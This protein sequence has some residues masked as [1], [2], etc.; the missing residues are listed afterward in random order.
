MNATELDLVKAVLP[1]IGTALG[2]PLGAGAATFVASK[3]G[4]SDSSVATVK[5]TIQNMLGNPEQIAKLKEIEN[6]YQ[7][8]M[9]EAGYTHLEHLEQI[10][11]SV[12]TTQVTA[13]NASMQAESRSNHWPTYTWRPFIGFCFGFMALSVYFVLPLMKLPVP[14][15]PSEVWLGYGA[16]LGTA[17]FFRGK[18]QADPNVMLDNRG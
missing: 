3:L 10:N 9:A 16:I 8:K 11:Q 18:G 14:V 5:S 6:E 12:L 15:I 1:W 2:G 13:V 4:M 7:L 17:S